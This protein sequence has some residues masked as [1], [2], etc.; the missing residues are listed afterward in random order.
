MIERDDSLVSVLLEKSELVDIYHKV[1]SRIRLSRED[2]LQLYRSNDI[3]GIGHLANMEREQ[4]NGDVAYYIVNLHI[5]YSNICKNRCRFCAFSR[6]STDEDGGYEMSVEEI[7]EHAG[8]ARLSGATEIHIV[9]GAHPTWPFSRYLEMIGKLHNALP[10]VHLQAYTAIEIAHMAEMAKLTVRETLQELKK[11]GLG[12]MPGGGA[13]IFSR[14]VRSLV[15]PEK[16]AGEK[17]LEVMREAHQLGI[18][19]NATMLYGH[20]ETDEERIDH[21]LALRELQDETHGFMSFIPLA[22]HAGNTQLSDRPPT[23]GFTDLKTLAI[24]RLML[25]NFEHIKAFW[26]MLGVKLAQVSLWFGVDDIDGTVVEERITHAAG[27]ETPQALTI[28]ELRRLITEAGR[29][30][31]ERDTLYG[32]V[33]REM[34]GGY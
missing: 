2:G 24:G 11:A 18:R 12:S 27:A 8:Q 21:M 28:Q 7:L 29:V 25:D 23:T 17:W 30:P 5:N 10:H 9:G 14:R 3:L 13:E 15:C 1:R 6:G 16:L 22:F 4:K 20:V 34:P 32:Y 31:V 33:M 26:I 19:S